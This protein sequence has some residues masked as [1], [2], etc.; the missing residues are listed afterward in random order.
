MKCVVAEILKHAPQTEFNYKIGDEYDMCSRWPRPN[1]EYGE[2]V[3]MFFTGSPAEFRYSR[4]V[5]GGRLGGSDM[6]IDLLR[7]KI[8]AQAK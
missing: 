6:P 7:T 2:G 4:S 1:T 5:H 8:R 3:L